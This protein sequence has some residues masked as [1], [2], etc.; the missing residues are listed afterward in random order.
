M[1]ADRVGLPRGRSLRGRH[2]SAGPSRSPT[3]PAPGALLDLGRRHRPPPGR[4]PRPG[5][6]TRWGW[7]STPRRTPRAAPHGPTRGPLA[8]VADT[9]ARL[10]VADGA[11]DRVLVVFA[12]R[13]GPEI[14]RVLRSGRP[15]RRGHAGRRPPGRAGRAARAAARRPGQGRA[16][17]RRARAASGAGR[18]TAHRERAPA[19]PGGR[20]D[21]GRA[22]VR[23]PG[24]WRAT[25]SGRRSR[26]L[27]EPLDVTVSVRDRHL[28]DGVR[29]ILVTG[30]RRAGPCCRR[31]ASPVAP[32]VPRS[33]R[34]SCRP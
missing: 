23:T 25:T 8:V 13:N 14:A 34:L 4:R 1:V 32:R 6:R 24:T 10:P 27:A 3:G 28:P 12:P 11:V 7:S 5:C 2:A 33:H 17:G 29:A 15:A 26:T 31:R 30:C 19:G 21:A 22:W 16:P 9:W 20:R 18:A